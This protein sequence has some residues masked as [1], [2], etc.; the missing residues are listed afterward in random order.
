MAADLR[1][2]RFRL[3]ECRYLCAIC[4]Y[5]RNVP[6]QRVAL[7]GSCPTR[8]SAFSPCPAVLD[9]GIIDRP[10]ILR[11]EVTIFGFHCRAQ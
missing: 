5:R 2:L 10:K 9:E 1:R 11:T 3:R 4:R 7:Y 6:G 8:S